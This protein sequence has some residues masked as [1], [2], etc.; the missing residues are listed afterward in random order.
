MIMDQRPTWVYYRPRP[1][2]WQVRRAWLLHCGTYYAVELMPS[3]LFKVIVREACPEFAMTAM[4]CQPYLDIIDRWHVLM[5]FP[6]KLY[7]KK[8]GAF[9]D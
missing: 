1:T 3:P 4:F 6:V 7:F 8:K 9:V 2:F 5:R